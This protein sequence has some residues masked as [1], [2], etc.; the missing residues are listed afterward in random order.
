MYAPLAQAEDA[1]ARLDERLRASPIR[2]GWIERA[3]FAD[4]CASLWLE[5]SLAHL[6]DLVL[7]DA[8]MDARAPTAE[9]IRAAR[10]LAARRLLLSA[11]PG[12]AFSAEGLAALHGGAFLAPWEGEAEKP[13]A[14]DEPDGE[15]AFGDDG[16]PAPDDPLAAELAALDAALARTERALERRPAVD[17]ESR[18]PLVYDLDWDEDERLAH[19]R[20]AVEFTSG[21]PPV[22]AAAL[23]AALWDDI[24]PLQ[25]V[26]WLGRLL[27]AALLRQRGKTK[28]HLLCVN[29]G[30]RAVPR[31]R[32]KQAD[33]V[34]KILFWLAAILAAAEQGLRDH[35]RWLL[36]RAS[37]VGKLSGRRGNSHL[38]QALDLALARPIVT[39]ELLAQELK[40]SARAGQNLIAELGLREL[41]GRR[42]YRAWGIL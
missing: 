31:L 21:L 14:S 10:V 12:W 1:L 30:A 18:D 16:E 26:P 23:T 15:G 8:R 25:H 22:L 11:A 4:A 36:A 6:E 9:I 42:R 7:H 19:W 5:G 17:P 13:M 33:P 38:P 40:V 28:S 24:E 29:S 20:D 41:T 39:A 37:R 32:L 34:A 3:H 2:A 27:A 35:D